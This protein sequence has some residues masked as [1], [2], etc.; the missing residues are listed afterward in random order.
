VRVRLFSTNG[1]GAVLNVA[2]K[3]STASRLVLA[4]PLF[5]EA[6]DRG[7]CYYGLE[8]QNYAENSDDKYSEGRSFSCP[9]KSAASQTCFGTGATAINAVLTPGLNAFHTV[10]YVEK[11]TSPLYD[12]A[13]GV[14][15][16]DAAKGSK[17]AF[18]FGDFCRPCPTGA[19]CPGGNEIRSLPGY[20]VSGEEVLVCKQDSLTRCP[21]WDARRGSL[22]GK[23]YTGPAATVCLPL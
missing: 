20:F 9:S 7:V 10:R 11:C 13:Q 17:C 8:V 18:G 23:G 22:C 2:I 4:F 6:C 1:S 15:C 19:L 12:S 21:G 14:H 5:Q 3:E 16:S